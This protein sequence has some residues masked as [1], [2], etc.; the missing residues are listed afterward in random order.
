MDQRL[1]RQEEIMT[2]LCTW[3]NSAAVQQQPGQQQQPQQ[4]AMGLLQPLG[5]LRRLL[6]RLRQRR[7]RQW[8]RRQWEGARR[9]SRCHLSQHRQGRPSRQPWHT[10]SVK[11][12]SQTGKAI[13]ANGRN[14]DISS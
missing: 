4:T 10:A 2:N 5:K 14:G 12:G 9:P 7:A 3:I 1:S 8:T 13:D 11:I 6:Q